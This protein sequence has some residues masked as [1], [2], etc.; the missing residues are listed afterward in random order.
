[1]EKLRQKIT[2][3][4]EQLFPLATLISQILKLEEELEELEKAED[5]YKAISEMADCFIVCCGIYRFSKRVA[6]MLMSAVLTAA[7]ELG[8][9]DVMLKSVEAKWEFNKTR[10]WEFKDGKYHHVGEDEYD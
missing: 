10:K 5:M 2:K 4:H 3:E 9:L 6:L 1:M 7:E 8:Y